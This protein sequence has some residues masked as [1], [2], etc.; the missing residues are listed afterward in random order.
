[1]LVLRNARL[2]DGT[3]R[4]PVAGASVVIEGDRIEYAGTAPQYGETATVIDLDGLVLMPGLID[5]HVH[6]GGIVHLE[7]GE[8]N[9]V[10][11]KASDDYSEA[12]K[13]AI[14]NGVT[15]LRSCGDFFPDC[16]GVRDDI[17]AGRL[18]GPRLSV[19]GVQF[20]APGGHPAY[21]IMGGD[22]YILEHSVVMTDDPR[23]GREE[24]RRVVDGGVDFIKAQLA[25]F[26]AWNYPRKLPKLSLDVLEAV[27][28][29]AHK[30][31]RRVAV[32]SEAP[33]DAYDA[34][35]R[36]ADS[37]EHLMAVGSDTAD[38][39]DGLLDLMLK[40]GTY[41]VPT[42]AVTS[43]YTDLHS[44]PKKYPEF[45]VNLA[46][47]YRAGVN[48]VAGT[49]AGA[50]DI[51]FGEAAHIEMELLAG[52]GLSNMDAILAA[53]GKAAACLGWQEE[54]GTVEKGKLADLVAVS[55]DPLTN[56][57][58][59]RNVKLVV[60]DGK[61]VVDRLNDGPRG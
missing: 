17:N 51:Q 8:P 25:S 11:R 37:I 35:M 34:I 47:I 50:P 44:G 2:I 40:N 38:L 1:M 9:F 31:G 27:I 18:P 26:D 14:A 48:V 45:K 39:P 60:A 30:L 19:S 13:H 28:D 16:V 41:V 49:D 59:T 6:C 15:T 42:L 56:I 12:R 33:Q 29:E 52:V 20:I 53:T 23:V 54:L 4:E 57:S 22:P 10:D 61:V 7:E 32:H 55:G 5:L 43:L 36:G 46:A 58:D 24:V 3:G 21:T